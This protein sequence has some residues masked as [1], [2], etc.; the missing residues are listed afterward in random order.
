MASSTLSVPVAM[1][2][3]DRADGYYAVLD[4]GDPNVIFPASGMYNV[5][6]FVGDVALA[7]NIELEVGKVQIQ[8]QN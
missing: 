8:F 7:S 2:F 3:N 5:M 6:V 4:L 1:T